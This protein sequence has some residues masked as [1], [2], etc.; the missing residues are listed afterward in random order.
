M[1]ITALVILLGIGFLAWYHYP[2]PSPDP[3]TRVIPPVASPA[4]SID[5]KTQPEPADSEQ[6]FAYDEEFCE[7]FKQSPHWSYM[8]RAYPGMSEAQLCDYLQAPHVSKLQ[9]INV[10]A[11]AIEEFL[12]S[13]IADGGADYGHVPDLR[14]YL[15]PQAVAAMHDLSREQLVDKINNERSAEAAYWLARHYHQDPQTY[16]MLM[17]VAASYS[18]K[19]GL[20]LHAMNGCCSWTPGDHEAERMAAIKSHALRM[21]VKELGLPEAQEWPDLE[22][23]DDMTAAILEQRAAYV[24]EINEYSMEAHGEA[25]IK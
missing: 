14:Y 17:L 7:E 22:F 23:S 9:G 16:T 5:T 24:A 19:S 1:K 21:I 13:L 11:E 12:N 2:D 4:P 10:N 18:K 20:I 3:V 15:D 8:Q 6:Q 25:W